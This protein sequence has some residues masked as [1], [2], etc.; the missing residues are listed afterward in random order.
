MVPAEEL[1]EDPKPSF[2]PT[3]PG[4]LRAHA[5]H[6]P[7]L[8][9][10]SICMHAQSCPNLCN[11]MDYSP[12]DSSLHGISQGRILEWLPFFSSRGSS[13]P[14]N[15]TWVSCRS[16]VKLLHPWTC[17]EIHFEKYLQGTQFVFPL[18]RESNRDGRNPNVPGVQ[19]S[20]PNCV[21]QKEH[22]IY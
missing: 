10:E 22:V 8:E 21:G 20:S 17:T 18:R 4:F 7:S 11:P 3:C 13:Q 19:A 9:I 6:P 1:V 5:Y 14:R 12:S 15:Q 16:C 2:P